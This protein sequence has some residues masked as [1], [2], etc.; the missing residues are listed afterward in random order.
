MYS[1]ET[2]KLK[3]SFIYPRSHC[4]DPLYL[5]SYLISFSCKLYLTLWHHDIT[6]WFIW[7]NF[8]ESFYSSFIWKLRETKKKKNFV[9]HM[10]N[11]S[12][13]LLNFYYLTV[14]FSHNYF[15]GCLRSIDHILIVDIVRFGDCQSFSNNINKS[16]YCSQTL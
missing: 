1:W 15:I 4:T 3:S 2:N 16:T 9:P 10:K 5:L 11:S 7:L 6:I 12:N 13:S 8:I 14:R